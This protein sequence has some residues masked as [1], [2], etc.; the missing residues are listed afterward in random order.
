MENIKKVL[1][2]L[3]VA[4]FFVVA[5]GVFK[6]YDPSFVWAILEK[7]P[8]ESCWQFF[9]ASSIIPLYVL[10]LVPT[11][12]LYCAYDFWPSKNKM[13]FSSLRF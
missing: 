5:W 2:V 10:Y 7:N 1:S 4:T 9:V 12:C 13:T 11:T 8:V 3:C 6:H